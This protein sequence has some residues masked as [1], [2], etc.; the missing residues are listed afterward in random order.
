[1]NGCVLTD[2]QEQARAIAKKKALEEGKK[3]QSHRAAADA[4][5][6]LTDEKKKQF[7]NLRQAMAEL[8]RESRAKMLELLSTDDR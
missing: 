2:E 3:G 8:T 5:V 4:A 1:M 6:R 7:Q